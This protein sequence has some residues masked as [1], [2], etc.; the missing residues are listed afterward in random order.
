MNIINKAEK[1]A[2][3]YMSKYDD[4]HNF[5]HALRVKSLATKIALSEGLNNNEI[6]EIIMGSILHDIND[7]KYS[8]NN[9]RQDETLRIFFN[10][11]KD[12]LEENTI[13]RII[14][15]ACNV[16]LTK[17]LNKDNTNI[18]NYNLEKQLNCIRDADRIESL[19]ALGISR[20][21]TYGIINNKSNIDDVIKNIEHRTAILLNH[22]KT[23]MGKKISAKKYIIIKSFIDDYYNSIHNYQNY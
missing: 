23:D 3:E 10:S 15:L 17:E 20:Y 21:F 7:H 6:F 18:I 12:E 5:D 11:I 13:N 22:I 19:G 9:M 2:K 8:N 1:Y 4:S 16:S 14:Y